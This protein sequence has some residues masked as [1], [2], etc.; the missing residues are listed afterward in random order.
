MIADG[1]LN[2]PFHPGD[3]NS[4]EDNKGILF[5]YYVSVYLRLTLTVE[6]AVKLETIINHYK[7]EKMASNI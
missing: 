3:K 5:Y 4:G 1:L 7:Q 6:F 2:F